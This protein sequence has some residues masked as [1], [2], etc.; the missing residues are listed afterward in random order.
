MKTLTNYL[1]F[2]LGLRKRYRVTGHSMWPVLRDGDI[3]FGKKCS[4]VRKNDIV[5]A[6]HPLKNILIIKEVVKVED[7]KVELRGKD[8]FGDD[9]RSFGMVGVGSV[10]GVII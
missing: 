9:S 6:K 1:L 10:V 7:G 4:T 8:E 2:F 5:V 3:V